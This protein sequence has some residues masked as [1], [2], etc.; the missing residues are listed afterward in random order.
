MG[1]RSTDDNTMRLF[2]VPT[3]TSELLLKCVKPTRRG[4]IRESTLLLLVPLAVTLA[5]CAPETFD[6]LLEARCGSIVA[7]VI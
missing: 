6:P 1:I 5:V 3:L 4:Y 7:S 2:Y